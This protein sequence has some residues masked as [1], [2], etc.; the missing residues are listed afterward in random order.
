V[1]AEVVVVGD[2]RRERVSRSSTCVGMVTGER[3][4]GVLSL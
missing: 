4:S 2:A 1:G 3:W